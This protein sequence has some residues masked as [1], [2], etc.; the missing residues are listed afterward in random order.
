MK[1][2]YATYNEDCSAAT[3]LTCNPN[4]NGL[5]CSNPQIGCVCPITV[6]LN[7]C[8]SNLTFRKIKFITIFVI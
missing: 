1:V 7:Y 6:A 2:T 5:V 8:G 3:G 4:K